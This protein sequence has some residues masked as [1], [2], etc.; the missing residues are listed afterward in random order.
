[1]KELV[2]FLH[3]AA[4]SGKLITL[5]YGSGSRPGKA[6]QL[7]VVSCTENG[8]RAYEKGSRQVKQYKVSKVIWAEDSSGERLVNEEGVE[9]FKSA[10]PKFETLQQYTNYLRSELEG[11]GWYVHITVNMIG[12]GTRFKNGKPKKTPSIAIR[13]FDRSTYEI[14]DVEKNE[15]VPVRK[16]RTGLERPWRVDSWRFKNGRSF[17]NLHSAMEIFME[18]VRG[19]DPS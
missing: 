1:M 10:L 2:R 17:G 7:I 6:R 14:W 5:A 4:R 19:S 15:L 18:E 9:E 11:A 3:E 16:E 12:V 13:Y 8:F